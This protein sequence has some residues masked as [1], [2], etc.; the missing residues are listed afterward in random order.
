V[1]KLYILWPVP[2][3]Y[4]LWPVKEEGGERTMRKEKGLGG[5]SHEGGRRKGQ[6]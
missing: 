3:L 1:S 4:I 5:G 6:V 2:K